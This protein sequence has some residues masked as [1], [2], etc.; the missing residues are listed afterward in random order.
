MIRTAAIRRIKNWGKRCR[1]DGAASVASLELKGRTSLFKA[2][3]YFLI[4]Y[5]GR[6]RPRPMVL[7]KKMITTTQ[8]AC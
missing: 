7:C 8:V 1:R 4:K 5:V 3:T 2:F 6:S